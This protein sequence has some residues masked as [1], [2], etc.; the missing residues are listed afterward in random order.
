MSL[1]SLGVYKSQLRT[2]GG[3]RGG[4]SST[5]SGGL[6]HLASE[7]KKLHQLNHSSVKKKEE[8]P[9]NNK[10]SL[11]TPRK[12]ANHSPVVTLLLLFQS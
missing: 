7:N 9:I 12:T 4:N 10:N 6:A 1:L 11:R 3:D 5:D 2:Q 8:N